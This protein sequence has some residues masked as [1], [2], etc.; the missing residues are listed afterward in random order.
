MR[1]RVIP[2]VHRPL[3]DTWL[4]ASAMARVGVRNAAVA[5]LCTGSGA[6]AI[7]ACMGGAGQVVAVDVSRRAVL[8]AWLN[9]RANA[10][11][12]LVR[13]GDLLR[14]LG[15]QRFDLIVSNPPYVPSRSDRLPRHS[16]A[17]AL[18]AGTDGRALIDRICRDARGHLLPGGSLLL[19]HS[20]ICGEQATLEL[21]G[22]QGLHTTVMARSAGA[23]GPVLSARA[24][25]LRAR[26]L[27]GEVDGEE[28]LVIRG[29]VPTTA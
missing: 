9:A 25:M 14:G 13:R 27:L 3:S 16:G 10:C 28:L 2:G 21:L 4:L 22:S 23:L 1:L 15:N 24:G 29:Q 6:L 7:A 19:V 26:G 11:R 20:S 8:S 17:R 5:D 18:D 12:V